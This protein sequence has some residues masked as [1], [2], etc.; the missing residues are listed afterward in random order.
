MY[1]E[2]PTQPQ[3]LAQYLGKISQLFQHSIGERQNPN[4]E[5]AHRANHCLF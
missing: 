2:T 5:D 4:A 1:H 3:Q